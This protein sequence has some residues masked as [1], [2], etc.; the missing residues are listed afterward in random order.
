VTSADDVNQQTAS[1]M[2]GTDVNVRKFMDI[3]TFSQ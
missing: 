3:F 1:E 2:A